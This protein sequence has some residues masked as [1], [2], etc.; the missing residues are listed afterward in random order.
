MNDIES[1]GKPFQFRQGIDLR[2][3]TDKKAKRFINTHYHGDFIF[4]FDHLEDRD[5]IIRKVQ[6]WKRYSSKVC[7][8]Y[9]ISAY[10]SQ[11]EKDIIDVFERIHT[12]MIYGSIPYIMR[13]EAYKKSPYK[14]LYIELA[15]W[16]N[17][18]NFFKKKSFREFC[19]ANQEY[20]KDKSKNCSA[21]QAMLNFEQKFPDIAKKYFDLRF[22][23]ENIY[24]NQYGYGRKYANKP[25]CSDCKRNGVCWQAFLENSVSEEDVLKAYF[26]KEL[27]LECLGYRNAECKCNSS[28]IVKKLVDSILRK[29]AQSII[30][31]IK[32][33]DQREDIT[34]DNI[35]QFSNID[36]ALYEVV[37]ILNL[38]MEILSFELIGYYLTRNDVEFVKNAVS[39]K[40]Y[41]ENHTKLATLI[42]LTVIDKLGVRAQIKLSELGKYYSKL[43]RN[44]KEKLA[45]KLCLRIP[46]IQNYF[47]NNSELIEE[48]LNI[49]SEET[50][51]RRRSSV[52]NVIK[53]VQE[54]GNL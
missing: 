49:L 50:K 12:L 34:K 1:F 25:L 53:L 24:S 6:L 43:D 11:D 31:L 3:M 40:K 52:M 29:S 51:K 36:H 5:L 32:E 20:K 15:R 35:P 2:L 17:Q 38:S 7:K 10:K 41:G 54:H 19:I 44:T 27:D 22:D 45:Y 47:I 23:E 9:V 13:Y 16:C 33:S 8:M 48:D 28:D 14:N 26:T 30:E 18:P 46:I 39:N 42:D 37:D 21:Y 4:A